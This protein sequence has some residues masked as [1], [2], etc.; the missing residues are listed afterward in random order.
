MV[1]LRYAVIIMST[2][3][4]EFTTGKLGKENVIADGFR[5]SLDKKRTT[6][7]SHNHDE[8]RAK[9]TVH[10]AK[11]VL[12]NRAASSD[13]STK[14]IV[15]S[16]VAGLDFECRAKLCC[17]CLEKMGCSARQAAYRY[18]SNPTSDLLSDVRS[19]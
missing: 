12:K 5:Y 2:S 13:M 1:Q 11:K 8:Q 3:T 10:K 15:A 14:H 4:I 6:A 9:I 18:P 16:A 7:P 19:R 17:N